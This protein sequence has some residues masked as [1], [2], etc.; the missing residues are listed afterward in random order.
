MSSQSDNFPICAESFSDDEMLLNHIKSEAMHKND[1]LDEEDIKIEEPVSKSD[2]KFYLSEIKRYCFENGIEC[3][4]QLE[5]I[6]NIL[7]NLKKH[8]NSS[9]LD[10]FR[11]VKK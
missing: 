4:D 7:L 3:Y 10:F 8:K 11:K 2:I 6:E 5:S 1:S 9:I